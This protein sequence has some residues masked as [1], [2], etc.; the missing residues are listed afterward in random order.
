LTSGIDPTRL[1]AFD[2]HVHLEHTGEAA[3]VDRR[4]A[5]YFKHAPGSRD[6]DAMADYYRSRDMA[7]V[8]FTVDETLTGMPRQSNDEVAAFVER[9]SDIAIAFGINPARGA[10]G[11]REAGRLVDAGGGQ[12]PEAAHHRPKFGYA[13]ILAKADD[14][15]R[16]GSH[17]WNL[18]RSLYG[19]HSKLLA[20]SGL[21]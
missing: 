21:P 13:L 10:D 19:R 17:L 5:A 16:Q 1:A 12:G 4:A 2:V 3:D 6:P 18:S 20:S 15:V 9:N 7:F 8:V 14:I 11:V